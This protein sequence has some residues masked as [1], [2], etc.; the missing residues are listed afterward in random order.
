MF[1]TRIHRGTL[2]AL[3]VVLA[4]TVSADTGANHQQPSNQFGTSGGNVNDITRAF[5]CSGTLGALVGDGQAL[6]ILSNNHVLARTNQ[7][8]P[9]EDVSQPGLIDNSCAAGTIVADLTAFPPLGST[10]VDAAVAELRPGTMDA[11]GVIMDIGVPGT[12][13]VAPAVDLSVQK[14]GRTTGHTAGTIGSINTNVRVQ[15][16]QNCGSGKKF[17]INYTN[18]FV[19][20]SSSFSAGG[21][22]GSLIVTN[23]ANRSPVGLLFAGSSTTTIAN[24]IDEVL[25][26][27]SAT[28]GR[29]VGFDL[30]GGGPG[31]GG[32]GGGRPSLSST[33]SASEVAR[34]TRAKDIHA[35]PLMADPA[36]L[37]VGVGQDPT[38]PGQAALVIYAARGQ[39]RAAIAREL[40]GVR[41]RVVETDPIVAYGWNSALGGVPSC[42]A[43]P[44]R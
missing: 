37:G 39:A 13:T 2:A 23:D 7:A 26:R 34:G 8:L 43:Q 21:D 41:T 11:T 28:L 6:Y 40:G 14:S 9:D 36:V 32:G 22:S 20:D 4:V 10:N 12:S 42:K 30:S 33:L 3:A 24:P 29:S 27:V 31:Q 18:Q 1:G 17:T 5:C 44:A 25:T 15:Y 19:V 16:Q 38:A 35:G